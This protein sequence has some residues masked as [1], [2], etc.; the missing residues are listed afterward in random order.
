VKPKDSVDYR[1][2]G[3]GK[4]S[5]SFGDFFPR[6]SSI[7]A[8]PSSGMTAGN[9][10]VLFLM[11]DALPAMI[12]LKKNRL[13]DVQMSETANRNRTTSNDCSGN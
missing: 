5:T 6:V 13:D 10:I 9:M 11:N 8:M 1:F 2:L 12:E 3:S 7:T 4:A